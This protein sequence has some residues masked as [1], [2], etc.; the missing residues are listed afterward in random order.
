MKPAAIVRNYT[1]CAVLLSIFSGGLMANCGVLD[2]EDLPDTYFFSSGGQNIGNFYPDVTLGP[3]VTGL[4]ESRFG[5]YDD[6]AFPPHSGDVVVWSPFDDPMTLAFS[7]PE[8]VVGFWYTSLNP[9]TLTVYDASNN[10]LGSM[11]RPANTDGTTGISTYLEFDGA[12][13]ALVTISSGAGQYVLDDLSVG[14]VGT[15]V[16]EPGTGLLSLAAGGIL[17]LRL[18]FIRVI[19]RLF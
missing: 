13:I 18:R 19:G 14:G 1:G 6:A 16:P 10:L 4:S 8:T 17:A 9:I 2:F 15:S 11:T 7:S 5:G 12:N 3:Y